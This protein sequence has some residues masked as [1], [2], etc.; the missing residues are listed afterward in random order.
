MYKAVATCDKDNSAP[1]VGALSNHSSSFCKLN[2]AIHSSPMI[3]QKCI[4]DEQ[5]PWTCDFDGM[6]CIGIVSIMLSVKINS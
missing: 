1:A 2:N 5:K 6:L 3:S 4:Q